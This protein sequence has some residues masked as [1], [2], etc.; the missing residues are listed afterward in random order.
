MKDVLSKR[1]GLGEIKFKDM[2]TEAIKHTAAAV[3]GFLMSRGALPGGIMP[4]GIAFVSSVP[5]DYL[6]L[7]ALGCFIGYLLPVGYGGTFRYLAALFAIIAI[8]ALLYAVTKYAERPLICALSAGIVSCATGLVSTVGDNSAS[9]MT[10]AEAVLALGGAYFIAVAFRAYPSFRAGVRGEELAALLITVNM[11]FCGLMTFTPGKISVGTILAISFILLV[12]R[13]GQTHAGSVCGIAA[14]FAAALSGGGLASALALALAGLCAGIFSPLGKYAQVIA[15]ILSATAGSLVGAEFTQTV[16]ILIESLFGSAL[17][18]LV[19]KSAAITAG[20]IFSPPAKTVSENG[21]KKAVTMRLRFAAGALSD[22]SRT[23]DTVAKELSRINSPD[24]EGVL[25]GIEKDACAG[26]SLCVNCWETRRADTVSA[27]LDMVK[28]VREGSTPTEEHAT[29]EF[30]SR[31]LRPV[32]VG[33]AVY[34][35]YSDYASRLAAESRI[36]DVR[37]VVSEQFSGISS[38]LSDLSEELERDEAFDERTASKIVASLKNLEIHACEC[39]CRIDKYG[40]M[41]VEVIIPA[42]RGAR[43][44]RMKLLRQLEICCDREFDPPVI[45][46]TAGKVYITLTEKAALTLD[47]GVCQL[48]C[49]P[50]GICGDAY[51]T[52]IDGKGRAFMILS[53]GMGCG[54]RAAVD[55]AM[56]SGLIARLLKAGFGYDCSLSIVNS[57]MLFKSTDESLAT[58][59]IACL[60]L[61]SG[62]T[63]MLK[64]GAAPTIIRRNGKCGVAQSTSLPA[65][66]LRE[67]GFDKATVKLK[68]GDIIVM[69]SDGV[70]TEGTDWICAELES[71]QDKPAK[72]LAEHLAHCARR[73]RTDNHQDDIT[74]VAAIVE[75]AV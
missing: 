56:A 43:Y 29:E 74:V 35:H 41:S 33:Q 21:M 30:R 31:C 48:P 42:I 13:F 63:D 69:M 57:A 51:N 2:L 6:A 10:V 70:T 34:L 73:R 53:D 26:C 8:K 54:G 5:A 72:Q 52:F 1:Q 66:I 22:V 40:R 58:V 75:K 60:D 71:W 15:A 68:A 16:E 32:K 20:R 62:R 59:D 17:F 28:S 65:G 14:G 9:L 61:F 38:M 47:T 67:V 4:F 18:L 27:V 46:E 37:S 50:S 24:F 23:V 36:A 7:S 39:G 3:C 44:N 55:G 19:P 25:K 64:A 11:L 49:S 12:S 45:T